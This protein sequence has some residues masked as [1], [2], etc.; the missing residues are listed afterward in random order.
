MCL[1]FVLFRRSTPIVSHLNGFKLMYFTNAFRCDETAQEQALTTF[2]TPPLIDY[3]L[4]ADCIYYQV[5]IT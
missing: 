3:I 4:V 1:R 2:G 5:L